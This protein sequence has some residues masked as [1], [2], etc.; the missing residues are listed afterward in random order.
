M[1]NVPIEAMYKFPVNRIIAISL[2]SGHR[3]KVDFQ[4]FPGSYEVLK[5]R[6]L[7]KKKYSV[8]GILSIITNS[9]IINSKQKEMEY[10]D[11]VSDYIALDLKGVGLLDDKQWEKSIQK[12]YEQTIA[13]LEKKG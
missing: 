13:Y 5:N 6:L 1:D 2:N 10:K 4:H 12:G 7:G 11:Q 8:P 3:K 9:L